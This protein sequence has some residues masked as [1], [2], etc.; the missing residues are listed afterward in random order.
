MTIDDLLMQ[1]AQKCKQKTCMPE[2]KKRANLQPLI[3]FEAVLPE[4]MLSIGIEGNIGIVQVHGSL[5][6]SAAPPHTAM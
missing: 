4:E 2:E 1:E 5:V 3:T 6:I